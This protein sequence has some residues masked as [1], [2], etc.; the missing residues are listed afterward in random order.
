MIVK[1]FV[2]FSLNALVN[3]HRDISKEINDLYSILYF[4]ARLRS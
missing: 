3:K 4:T 2:V 1:K